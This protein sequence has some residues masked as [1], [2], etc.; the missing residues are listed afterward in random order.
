ML[1]MFAVVLV[2]VQLF[3]LVEGMVFV[4]ATVNYVMLRH[5]HVVLHVTSQ[6]RTH[7][8]VVLVLTGLVKVA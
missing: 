3:F 7:A 4:Q 6:A 5:V 2:N 8:A 1:T